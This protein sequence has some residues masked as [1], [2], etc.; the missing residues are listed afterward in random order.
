MKRPA[1][2]TNNDEKL[3][4]RPM[5]PDCN[6]RETIHYLNGKIYVLPQH[7]MFRAFPDSS[8]PATEFKIKW[9]DDVKEAWGKACAKLEG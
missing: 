2:A 3:E 6:D 1:A 4:G 9:N 5:L 7:N 8:C